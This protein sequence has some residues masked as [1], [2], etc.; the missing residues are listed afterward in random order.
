M[1]F[2]ER[3]LD[4]LSFPVEKGSSNCR[5]EVQALAK[6]SQHLIEMEE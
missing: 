4:Y 1:K 2:H 6:V 3:P 5:V